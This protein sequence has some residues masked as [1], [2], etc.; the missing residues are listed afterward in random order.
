MSNLLMASWVVSAQKRVFEGDMPRESQR[1]FCAMKNEPLSFTLC[2]RA[3]GEAAENGRDTDLFFSAQITSSSLPLSVYKILSVPFAA[4]ECEDA[5]KGATGPCPDI[6]A[7]RQTC[8]TVIH[9]ENDR[10]LPYYEENE[11]QL[12][13]ASC[14]RT[15]GIYITVNPNGDAL[16]EGM[17][18]GIHEI[19]IRL[20]SLK[21]GELLGEHRVKIELIDALLPK[22]DLIYT[23]WIHY[24]CLADSSGLKVWSDKYFELLGRYIKNAVDGGM[25]TLLTPAFTPALDTPVGKERMNVQLVKIKKEPSGYSFDFGLLKRFMTLAIENGIEYF[26]HCHLFSQ[27]G[28]RT[29][30][31]IYAEDGEKLFGW[32]TPACDPEY[33]EFLNEYLSAYLELCGELGVSGKLLFHVSDE[34]AREHSEDYAKAVA[35]VKDVLSGH[36]IGDALSDYSFYELGLTQMPIVDTPFADDFDGKAENMMLYYTGGERQV[37]LSNRLLTSSPQK[38]RIL[39]L[40]LYRYRA[41]G[42]LH[43]GYNYTYGRMSAGLFDP[44]KDPCF[45]KNVPAVTYLVYSDTDKGPMP[46]LREMNMRDAMNDYRALKLCESLIGREETLGICEKVLGEKIGITTLPRDGEQ[47]IELRRRINEK[48]KEA[49]K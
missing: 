48:I 28:A 33:T 27:W 20:I 15:Q 6:L 3:L 12:L 26:E 21:T 7:K 43:W 25:N 39:G 42:F 9:N 13:T 24:D 2:Y 10:T 46:S 44:A 29:A 30:I 8:P 23:N 16:P 5:N 34:P 11:L 4:S 41:R 1:D 22:N 38:T 49:K 14:K 37:G 19:E 17:G 31:N 18:I 35:S 40:Q 45:Y 36:M 47:M 32:D